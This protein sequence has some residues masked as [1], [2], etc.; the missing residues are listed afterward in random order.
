MASNK[1]QTYNW[2][3]NYAYPVTFFGLPPIVVLFILYAMFF[4]SLK[5]VVTAAVACLAFWLLNKFG[6]TPKTLW[7][8]FRARLAGKHC[9]V[10]PKLGKVQLRFKM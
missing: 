2:W 6:Y 8:G 9:G 7:W 1:M 5:S 10:F 4:L 3:R